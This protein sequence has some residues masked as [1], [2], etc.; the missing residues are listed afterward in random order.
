[1]KIVAVAPARAMHREQA[2]ERLRP[3]KP[4]LR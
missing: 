1:L 3:D 4:I 2:I